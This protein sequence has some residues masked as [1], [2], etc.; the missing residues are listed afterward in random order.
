M[1]SLTTSHTLMVTH[2]CEYFPPKWL[3]LNRVLLDM[4]MWI[5]RCNDKTRRMCCFVLF[6]S[7]G[8][9]SFINN[10]IL[11]ATYFWS[12]SALMIIKQFLSHTL[13]QNSDD[14]N[15]F[16]EGLQLVYILFYFLLPS[17]TGTWK[18]N[19]TWGTQFY[20]KYCCQEPKRK[21]RNPSHPHSRCLGGARKATIGSPPQLLHFSPELQNWRFSE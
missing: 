20:E 1:V 18:V 16:S 13:A 17:H 21:S 19:S 11:I 2:S 15:Y 6:L 14:F 5:F 7:K 12:H 4:K 10:Q 8:P 9:L 3:H